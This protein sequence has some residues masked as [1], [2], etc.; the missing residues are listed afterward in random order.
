VLI[1][2]TPIDKALD[3]E[4]NPIRPMCQALE[5]GASLILFPE[6]T[7]GTG[8][9][10][11]PFKPGVF[12]LAQAHTEVDLVPVRIDNSYRV[13]PKGIGVPYRCFVR[14]HSEGH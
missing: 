9:C 12:H 10:V 5:E 4:H 6:G 14:W 8:E 3:R 1:E 13:M 2:R 7:R 11:Q